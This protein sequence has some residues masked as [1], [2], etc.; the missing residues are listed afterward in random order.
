[1][2]TTIYRTTTC[3]KCGTLTHCTGIGTDKIEPSELSGTCPACGWGV[4]I[5]ADPTEPRYLTHEELVERG[6]KVKEKVKNG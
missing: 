5:D 1:M 4:V 2:A 6:Q 3:P